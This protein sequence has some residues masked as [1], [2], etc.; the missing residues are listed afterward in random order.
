MPAQHAAFEYFVRTGEMSVTILPPEPY[1]T[2]ECGIDEAVHPD[3]TIALRFVEVAMSN[4]ECGCKIYADPYS[5]VRVL[6][7]SRTYGCNKTRHRLDYP[8][9]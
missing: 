9:D 7:H 5:A 4:C 8:K 3:R 1:Y 2:Y 6:V